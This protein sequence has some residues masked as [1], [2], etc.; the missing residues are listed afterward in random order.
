MLFRSNAFLHAKA[1]HI[2]T[3]VIFGERDLRI[4]VRDDGIGVD[5]QV[6]ARGQR[7]GHWGLPGIRERSE[8]LGGRLSIWSKKNQGTEVE[9]SIAAELA[10]A[11]PPTGTLTRI[12]GLLLSRRSTAT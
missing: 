8:N 1:L 2:Q 6:L 12:R 10:Y 9:L 3:E 5:P 11:M 4:R 7:T